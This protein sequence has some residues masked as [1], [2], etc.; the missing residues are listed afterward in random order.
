MA[1][2]PIC[3]CMR[4]RSASPRSPT[5]VALQPGMIVSNEPGYYKAGAYGIRIENLVAVKEAQIEGGDRTLSRV[6]DPDPGADRPQLRRAEPADRGREEPGSTPITPASARSW[7]RRSTRRRAPGSKRQPALSRPGS[8]DASPNPCLTTTCPLFS[9]IADL[10]HC[11]GSDRFVPK[12]DLAGDQRKS[13]KAKLQTLD[14][15]QL[16]RCRVNEIRP[17]SVLRAYGLAPPPCRI[18]RRTSGHRGV[19]INARRWRVLALHPAVG[20]VRHR[21]PQASD[22]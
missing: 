15:H 17:S 5:T 11:S 18:D 20:P 2:A 13:A 4:A 21:R 3:R 10:L 9:R 8:P 12:A 22:A 7:R 1:S 19:A 6:R 14:R 16:K